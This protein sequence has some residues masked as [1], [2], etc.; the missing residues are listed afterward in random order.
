M[1][2]FT[3]YQA[4]TKHLAKESYVFVCPSPE[5]QGRV[6]QKRKSEVST[7][8]AQNAVDFFGWNLSCTRYGAIPSHL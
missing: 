2:A 1:A 8:D 6:V 5:T 4:L 7:E 3:A